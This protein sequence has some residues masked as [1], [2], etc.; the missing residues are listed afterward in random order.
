MRYGNLYQ[1]GQANEKLINETL[2]CVKPESLEKALVL[3]QE[4]NS[5][6]I[7]MKN[8]GDILDEQDIVLVS[9]ACEHPLITRTMVEKAMAVKQQS[10]LLLIDLSVP[11]NVEPGIDNIPGVIFIDGERIEYYLK[12]DGVLRQLRRGTLGTG[13]ATV[14][15]KGCLLY[16]SDAA[17][18]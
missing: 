13:I 9:T 2:S 3:A 6:F 4:T 16:T 14:H 1:T 17:D 12:E 10:S 8:I 5:K 15:A 18:E 11:R 7:E